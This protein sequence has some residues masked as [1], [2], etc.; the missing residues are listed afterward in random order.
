MIKILIIRN[1][2]LKLKLLIVYIIID[3]IL[4]QE[5]LHAITF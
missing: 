1:Y 3:T 4:N 2:H 5:Y